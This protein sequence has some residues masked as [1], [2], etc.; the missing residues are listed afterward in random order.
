MGS[1]KI[2]MSWLVVWLLAC[3]TYPP[4]SAPELSYRRLSVTYRG[5]VRGVVQSS[6]EIFWA[7]LMTCSLVEGR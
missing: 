6:R 5:F 4:K 1:L 7:R 2:S 3:L